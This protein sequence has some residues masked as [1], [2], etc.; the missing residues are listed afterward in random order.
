MEYI[1]YW[2]KGQANGDFELLA[3]GITQ[4]SYIATGLS[5]ALT[6]GFKVQSRN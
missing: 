6:Y 1:V 5:Q 4:Q 3:Q 2:D